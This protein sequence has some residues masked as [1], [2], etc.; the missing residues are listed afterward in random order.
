MVKSLTST[1]GR[2]FGIRRSGGEAAWR[3]K[4][5]KNCQFVSWSHSRVCAIL[6][7]S[8]LVHMDIP[9]DIQPTQSAMRVV[10]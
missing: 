4:L 1:K 8:A 10:L 3:C 9:V 5:E 7:A 2:A 6:R